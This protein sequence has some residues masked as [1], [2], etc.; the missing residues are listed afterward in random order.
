MLNDTIA[1]LALTISE[2]LRAERLPIHITEAE[3]TKLFG[4]NA[5]IFHRHFSSILQE[6][7]KEGFWAECVLCPAQNG[8]PR[9]GYYTF[10]RQGQ[11]S[12]FLSAK[13]PETGPYSIPEELRS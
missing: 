1:K 11:K 6:I 12:L 7:Q 5:A 2:K 13:A 4:K 8:K 9:T 10:Y 3:V